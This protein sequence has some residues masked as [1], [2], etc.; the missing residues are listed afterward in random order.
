VV[1]TPIRDSA[2]TLLGFAKVTRDLTARLKADETR[3]KLIREQTR[4]RWPRPRGASTR[5]RGAS[6]R[7]GA[8][9]RGG[10]S[11]QGRVPGTL[12]H[13]LRTP[14]NA[15]LG[16]AAVLEDQQTSIPAWPKAVEVIHR[17]AH[18]QA[19]SLDRPGSTSR[20]SSPA[21]C[22]W[23][24]ADRCDRRSCATAI[25]VWV[26]AP[27]RRSKGVA[28]GFESGARALLRCWQK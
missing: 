6:S 28:L 25:E 27:R 16:W 5:E 17:N 7:A 14:L 21:S 8:A 23:S 11:A 4:A 9:R 13:E 2:G 12:S 3:A 19:A 20:A 10:E 15:I 26:R 22:A 24:C 18:A 1:L